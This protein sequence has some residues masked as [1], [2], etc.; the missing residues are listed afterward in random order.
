MKEINLYFVA[1]KYPIFAVDLD[2]P[3][4]KRVELKQNIIKYRE[5]NPESNKSN[6]KAWHSDWFTQK[7]DV[8]KNI[9]Q[10]LVYECNKI[11]QDFLKSDEELYCYNMW[12]NMYEKDDYTVLHQHFPSDYS[13]C[14]YVDVEENCSPIKFPPKLEIT[15]KNDML[16]IFDSNIFHEVPPTKGERTLI[17]M[18][19]KFVGTEPHLC[20]SFSYD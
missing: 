4:D 6:V 15:P 11:L 7:N 20:K 2:L 9:S 8:F 10:R 1:K 17:S 3:L 13:I 14:Y 12:I 5:N 16:L 18:N 19:L